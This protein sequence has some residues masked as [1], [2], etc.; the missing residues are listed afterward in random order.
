MRLHRLR[1]VHVDGGHQPARL[2]RADRDQRQV[3]WPQ[4][5]PD[6]APV[7]AVAGIACKQD[8]PV[9]GGQVEPGPE[10]AVAVPRAAAAEMAGRRRGQPHRA[11]GAAFPPV[12]RM[13]VLEPGPPQ[14]R[15][16]AQGRDRRRRT[17][18]GQAPEGGEV[19][20]VV[21]IVR[22]QDQVDVRQARQRQPRRAGA[23]GACPAH[24][25]AAFAEDRVGQDRHARQLQ[26]ERRVADEGHRGRAWRHQRGGRGI[27][28]VGR[29]AAATW[30]VHP[31]TASAGFRP[32]HAVRPPGR[33]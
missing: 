18:P 28:R 25:G 2:A 31:K 19:E 22:H 24:G 1:R 23:T 9:V 7:R 12:H 21:V 30:P 32:R 17:P 3:R 26:Q 10:R 6:R 15:L 8:L 33:G 27:H 29:Q 16:V 4:P 11:G 20:V 13:H 5:F 14:D